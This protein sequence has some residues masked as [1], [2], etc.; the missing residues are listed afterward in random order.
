MKTSAKI[1]I[2][3]LA[4]VVFVQLFSAS[5][6]SNLSNKIPNIWHAAEQGNV[7]ALKK[8]IEASQ[9]PNAGDSEG[10]TPLIWASHRMHPEA[11]KYLISM[12]ADVNAREINGGS[13]LYA[14]VGWPEIVGL[15]LANGADVNLQDRLGRTPLDI[16]RKWRK[17][18][19]TALL[20]SAK[21]EQ[22]SNLG[23]LGEN[24]F[25]VAF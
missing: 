18:R 13:A 17:N 22:G 12:G 14:G 20:E 1:L 15:L 21:A 25:E 9:D 8:Y 19:S 5:R 10:W 7:V 24:D 23:E 6:N 11:V 2:L 3:F 16:A 4:V